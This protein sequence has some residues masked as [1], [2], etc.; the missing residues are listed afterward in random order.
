VPRDDVRTDMSRARQTRTHEAHRAKGRAAPPSSLRF[1]SRTHALA[2]LKPRRVTDAISTRDDVHALSASIPSWRRLHARPGVCCCPL[3]PFTLT[4]P[5]LLVGCNL[6]FRTLME[7][8]NKTRKI[9]HGA[10]GDH[11]ARFSCRAICAPERGQSREQPSD[12]H[13]MQACACVA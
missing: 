9:H 5:G 8:N 10:G 3:Q 2:Q 4:R 12:T 6:S 11:R 1:S 7:R 13:I